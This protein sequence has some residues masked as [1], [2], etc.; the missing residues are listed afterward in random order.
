[1]Q[2]PKVGNYKVVPLPEPQTTVARCYG[3]VD[4]GT[5]DD[6]YPGKPPSR[7]RKLMIFW[8]LPKLVAVF[9]D[10]KG[11][12]PFSISKEISYSTH[13]DSNLSKLVAAW[14][15]RGFTEEEQRTFDPSVMIGKTCMLNF[16]VKRKAKYKDSNEPANTQNSYPELVSIM[17][18]LPEL[19][20]SVPPMI[21]QELRWD[22]DKI[23]NN[24][25]VFDKEKLSLIY[26]WVRQKIYESDEF[27]ECPTAVNIDT[28][29]Q[30]TA[31]S[32]AAP[33]S[34]EESVGDDW[35]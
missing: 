27:A 17:G 30:Q 4:L 3:V 18:L 35:E 24:E 11:E 23:L 2:P 15:G 21:N 8:E 10:E 6:T 5:V 12:Q 26:P 25:E 22:W 33:E 28:N 1:M 19:K 14:K 9:S 32:E 20:G 7:K 29:D 34:A 13:P 16:N 31:Y